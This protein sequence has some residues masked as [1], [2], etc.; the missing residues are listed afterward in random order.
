MYSLFVNVCTLKKI[1]DDQVQATQMQ[2]YFM[3][4]SN[5]LIKIKI[6]F[7]Q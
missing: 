6:Y 5:K 3:V 4:S 7:V 2:L 1:K